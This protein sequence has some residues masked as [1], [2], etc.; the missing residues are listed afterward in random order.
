MKT[1]TLP[2]A[3][4][5]CLTFT[6]SAHAQVTLVAEMPVGQPF[7][8]N[9]QSIV[10]AIQMAI[11]D[12]GG[13]VCGGVTVNELTRD[14]ASADSFWDP[15]V[16]ASNAA[17][18]V[19]DPSVLG[20]VGTY[21]SGAAEIL[22]PRVN[23]AHLAV[24]SPANTYP[25]L[26]KPGS[27]NPADPAEYY[28][29]GIRNYARVIPADD[30]QGAGAADWAKQI[31]VRTVYIVNDGGGY[32]SG[33]ARTFGDEAQRIGLP[34]VGTATIQD[35]PSPSIWR[36][37][38]N[39]A[40][41]RITGSHADLVF[42]GGIEG[43]Q[44]QALF[45]NLRRNQYSGQFMGADGLADQGFIDQ[46]GS[47]AEGMYVTLPGGYTPTPSAAVAAWNIDYEKRFFAPPEAYTLD[48]YVAAQVLLAAL[49]KSCLQLGTDGAREAVR[50]AMMATR[51][52]DSLLGRFSFDANGDTSI[53]TVAVFQ[54]QQ[55]QIT[56]V[57]N[58]N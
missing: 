22:I 13:S 45:T 38:L 48:G 21:N 29:N 49:N 47:V 17:A 5:A 54:V 2:L 6:S 57:A 44:A 23:P 51:D 8:P 50:A 30:V 52:F 10:N 19:G 36:A 37:S 35:G 32:G 58:V 28:P 1:T 16:V 46:L 24:V 39:E 12:A 33:M 34:V 53:R 15:S 7:D 25:G 42:F 20:I 43:W 40:V 9:P 55:G 11:A 14:E 3:L 18:D 56:F 31:G 4:L 41:G 26:T 27:G